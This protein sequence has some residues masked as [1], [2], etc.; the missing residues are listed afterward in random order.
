MIG[1][2]GLWEPSFELR[3][4]LYE[5]RRLDT[6]STTDLTKSDCSYLLF[7]TLLVA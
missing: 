3:V 6:Y 7:A 1:G 5:S 4:I 2:E